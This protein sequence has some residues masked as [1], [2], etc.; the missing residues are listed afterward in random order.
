MISL[1]LAEVVQHVRFGL[2]VPRIR[3]VV[4]QTHVELFHLL[5]RQPTLQ[6]LYVLQ[7]VIPIVFETSSFV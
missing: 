4:S 2:E 7:K 5:H 1:F 6:H 3:V